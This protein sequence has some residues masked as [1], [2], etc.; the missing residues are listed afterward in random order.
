MN[1]VQQRLI[2]VGLWLWC[3]EYYRGHRLDGGFAFGAVLGFATT[4]G[5]TAVLVLTMDFFLGA[6][7]TVLGRFRLAPGFHL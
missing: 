7:L 6:G 3:F 1:N 4:F 5:F 2:G